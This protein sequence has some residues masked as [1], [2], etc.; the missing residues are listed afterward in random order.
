MVRTSGVHRHGPRH[1]SCLSAIQW[2][3][4]A[5][6]RGFVNYPFPSCHDPAF[7]ALRGD[8]AIKAVFETARHRWERFEV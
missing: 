4:I 5:I 2:L 3:Q 6:D 7:E 1:L 8:S